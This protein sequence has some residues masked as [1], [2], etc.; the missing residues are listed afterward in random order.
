MKTGFYWM[1][2]YCVQT[3]HFLGGV[4]GATFVSLTKQNRKTQN[5]KYS[6]ISFFLKVSYLWDTALKKSFGPCVIKIWKCLWYGY[7]YVQKKTHL[8]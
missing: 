1:P 2:I 4:I 3:M 6:K 8:A 7:R 5:W